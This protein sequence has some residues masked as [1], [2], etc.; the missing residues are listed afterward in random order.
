MYPG[1]MWIDHSQQE[2]ILLRVGLLT[3]NYLG[4]LIRVPI[5]ILCRFCC[6]QT[7]EIINTR[8]G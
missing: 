2:D 1:M 4:L 3:D 6:I 7:L 5:N 8:E